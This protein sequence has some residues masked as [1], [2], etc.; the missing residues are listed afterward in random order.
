MTLSRHPSRAAHA[1][2]SGV[3]AGVC[4][5]VV[6]LANV[7]CSAAQDLG[8]DDRDASV[9][10]GVDLSGDDQGFGN[11]W[12]LDPSSPTARDQAC[13][14]TRPIEDDGCPVQTSAPCVY[15]PLTPGDDDAICL[16]TLQQRWTCLQGTAFRELDTPLSPG[17]PC[18]DTVG[19]DVIRAC[20]P[21]ESFWHG[22]ACEVAC[23]CVNDRYRC[24]VQ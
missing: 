20:D 22:G 13:P 24:E 17:D 12:A 4:A 16:C 21:V 23:H 5:F 3:R 19:V 9:E 15:P 11:S 6:L 2:W 18:L 1:R 8:R 10:G 14:L 7:G